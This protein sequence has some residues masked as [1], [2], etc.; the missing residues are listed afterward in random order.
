MAD[1]RS[2]H[3]GEESPDREGHPDPPAPRDPPYEPKYIPPYHPPARAPDMPWDEPERE[4]RDPESMG[5]S[6]DN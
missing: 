6:V 4:P 2:E 5:L 1:P 3:D